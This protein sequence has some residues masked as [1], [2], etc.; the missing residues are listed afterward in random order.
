M[1]H[2]D[3]IA[4]RGVSFKAAMGSLPRPG[5]QHVTQKE[6]RQPGKRKP[7]PTATTLRFRESG[8]YHPLSLRNDDG[9]GDT[10]VAARIRQS[11]HAYALTGLPGDWMLLKRHFFSACACLPGEVIRPIR[12]GL[13]ET[14]L[15][16]D[17]PRLEAVELLCKLSN[18]NA[19]HD[20]YELQKYLMYY[21]T[22]HSDVT[23]QASE[24]RKLFK[25]L[26]LCSVPP[27]AGFLR[28]IVQTAVNNGKPEIAHNLLQTLSD[29]MTF[30]LSLP[31]VTDIIRGYGRQLNWTRIDELV[32]WLHDQDLSRK[33]PRAFAA[34]VRHAFNLFAC[35]NPSTEETYDFLTYCLQSCGMVPTS[36][37]SNDVLSLLVRRRR[38][39]LLHRWMKDRQTHFPGLV[40]PARAPATAHDIANAWAARSTRHLS[41]SDILATCQALARGAVRN[42]FSDEFRYVTKEVIEADISARCTKLCWA[43]GSATLLA[44]VPVPKN[45]KSFQELDAYASDIISCADY[46]KRTH[47]LRRTSRSTGHD[48]QVSLLRPTRHSTRVSLLRSELIRQLAAARETHLLLHDFDAYLKAYGPPVL[49]VGVLE[50]S[51]SVAEPQED[52][53]ISTFSEQWRYQSQTTAEILH[54]I[55][56]VYQDLEAKGESIRRVVF[57]TAFIALTNIERYRSVLALLHELYISKWSD[58]VFNRQILSLWVRTAMI[59]SNPLALREAL[60]AVVDS[61]SSIELPARF[62]VLVRLAQEDLVYYHGSGWRRMTQKQHDEIE[63]LKKRIYRR[64]WYQM[65]CPGAED[66]EE[67]NLREWARGMVHETFDPMNNK[68]TANTEERA[69]KEPADS[70]DSQPHALGKNM[71]PAGD[72]L[73]QLLSTSQ[74]KATDGAVAEGHTAA[75]SLDRAVVS[76]SAPLKDVYSIGVQNA[77]AVAEE[78]QGEPGRDYGAPTVRTMGGC[79]SMGGEATTIVEEHKA[80]DH[81]GSIVHQPSAPLKDISSTKGHKWPSSTDTRIEIA[82]GPGGRKKRKIRRLSLPGREV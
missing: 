63:Y 37:L 6:R 77:A 12:D 31:M 1:S 82:L 52:K 5:R 49:D 61:P 80:T 71:V 55:N 13:V 36:K 53:M 32:T 26:Q 33:K 11:L 38:Y 78:V 18:G 79:A 8:G 19:E 15:Q 24:A 47:V 69:S 28:P 51:E 21:C 46:D 40:N 44:K 42:E 65:G 74:T 48:T 50:Q 27:D 72:H 45:F 58:R 68:I 20:R 62:L 17:P 60:W 35:Y 7:S 81:A 30:P 9:D 54:H 29:E 25:G 4:P 64:K 2:S 73:M 3:T 16:Q 75:G 34:V 10:A 57:F 76:G 67:P 41:A 59:V 39:D 70:V 66:I 56:A 22:K 43:V 23:L 14:L